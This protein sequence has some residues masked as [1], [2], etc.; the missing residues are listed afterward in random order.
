MVSLHVKQELIGRPVTRIF[1]TGGHNVWW[2][3]Y[4]SSHSYA[5]VS[6]KMR[7]LFSTINLVF[8]RKTHGVSTDIFYIKRCINSHKVTLL[9]KPQHKIK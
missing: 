4:Q 3:G 1:F 8:I 6:H 2:L 7:H 9:L 5:T